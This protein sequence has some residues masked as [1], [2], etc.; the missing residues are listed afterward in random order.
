MKKI[1]SFLITLA[2][3]FPTITFSPFFAEISTEEKAFASSYETWG[4][5]MT[6]EELQKYYEDNDIR[7]AN[8]YTDEK[9]MQSYDQKQKHLKNRFPN[10]TW[11]ISNASI[12]SV[13]FVY[14]YEPE[15]IDESD[16][17]IQTAKQ[18][19]GN[20]K[21]YIGCGPLALLSQ[22][23]FL[24]KSAGY[25]MLLPN[26]YED[27]DKTLL[28]KEVIESTETVA[29]GEMG[30]FAFPS[31]V[32]AAAREILEKHN[33]A[34][35]KSRQT[36]LGD[37]TVIYYDNDSQI[38]VNGDM[39]PNGS[40]FSVKIKNLKDSIDK[41]MP[42]IWWTTNLVKPYGGHYMNIYGYEYWTGVDENG[43]EIQH[44]LFKIN[45]NWGDYPY[46]MDSD[47]LRDATS[48]FIFFEEIHKKTL[49]RPQDYGL[50]CKYN[51]TEESKNIGNGENVF[52]IKYLRTGYVKRF[53]PG[54]KI[55]RDYQISLSARR[56][57]AGLAYIE[58]VAPKPIDWL[59]FEASWWSA[60]EGISAGIGDV[61]FQYK[62]V[63]TG[64]WITKVDLLREVPGGLSKV[65][66]SKTKFMYK[67][68]SPI[69]EFRIIVIS[70]LPNGTRNTGRLVLGNVLCIYTELIDS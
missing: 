54:N 41:G 40:A 43:N 26:P 27:A 56:E 20:T 38:H 1:L 58:Y 17:Y 45:C 36:E 57:N 63:T 29:F 33:L 15:E 60:S 55:V 44:L 62:D 49:I 10:Y 52:N 48:G 39:V 25:R 46:Y 64:E 6:E 61:W 34:I 4:N 5:D 31:S 8:S 59:Y 69:Q 35:Q 42:V 9:P 16:D 65:I 21:D 23:Q 66:D 11:N 67:F 53:K 7:P 37:R 22:L 70:E 14:P 47:L 19:A 68:D 3:I 24:G 12:R 30:T 2:I 18:L 51:F 50:A 32:V 28:A 13:K